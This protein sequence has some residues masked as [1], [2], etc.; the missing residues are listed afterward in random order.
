MDGFFQMN[1]N[2]ETLDAGVL[3][4]QEAGGLLGDF[5]GGNSFRTHGDTV[6]GNAKL[7]KALLQAIRPALS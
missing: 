3:L 7:F 5:H 6:A 2:K 1:L 4:I